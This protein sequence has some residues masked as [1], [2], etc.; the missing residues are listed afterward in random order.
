MVGLEPVQELPSVAVTAY[1]VPIVAPVVNVTVAMPLAFVMLVPV[2]SDPPVPVLFHVTEM[3]GE[4]IGLPLPLANC[5][6]MVTVVP[7]TGA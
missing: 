1:S 3:P 7:A 6:V 5:A 2:P 4:W